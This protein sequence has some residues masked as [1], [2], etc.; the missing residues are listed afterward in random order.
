MLKNYIKIIN[1]AVY[2]FS[3]F[4]IFLSFT[5]IY[6]KSHNNTPSD[7]LLINSTLPKNSFELA[8]REEND[9][10]PELPFNIQFQPLKMQLPDLRKTLIYFG[11]NDRPDANPKESFMHFGIQGG[12][13][14]ASTTMD[15]LLYLVYNAD[16]KSA[17]PYIFSPLNAETSLWFTANSNSWG[18]EVHL[19]MRNEEGVIVQEQKEHA[20]FGI[21]EQPH[22]PNRNEAWMVGN[23]RVDPSL[24]ARQKAKWYGKDLFLEEHGGEEFAETIQKE[25]IYFSEQ[26]LPHTTLVGKDSVMI[27]KDNIWQTAQAGSQTTKYP[28]ITLDPSD[29]RVLKLKIFDE[30][31]QKKSFLNLVHTQEHWNG[32]IYDKIFKCVS[33]RTRSMFT[34][35]IDGVRKVLS[36]GDWLL[37]T[38]RGWIALETEEQIDSFVAREVQG[39]LF[40][41][42]GPSFVEGVPTLSGTLYSPKR[43]LSAKVEIPLPQG[44]VSLVLTDEYATTEDISDEDE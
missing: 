44:S 25:L 27:F 8:F 19:F 37:E 16:D 9:N 6:Q 20:L 36:K 35:E 12:H 5:F 2:T 24:L 4:L 30:E 29:D 43:T 21:Q 22:R 13:Q 1:K 18:A 10:L 17:H 23:L 11:R 31:G 14:K 38:E 40:I 34:F 26:Q 3:F 15:G 39:T 7:P 42:D 28:L 33:A 41:F 32:K